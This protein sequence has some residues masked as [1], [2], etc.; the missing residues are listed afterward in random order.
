MYAQLILIQLTELK[1][2]EC[3]SDE[4]QRQPCVQ[5]TPLPMG[6]GQEAPLQMSPDLHRPDLLWCCSLLYKEKSYLFG[7][8][9]Y[10][11]A[12]VTYIDVL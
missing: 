11:F 5:T 9:V 2:K 8:C 4:H 10:Q 12:G 1:S 3:R 6:R 7:G